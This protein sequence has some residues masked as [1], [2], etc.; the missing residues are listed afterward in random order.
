MKVAIITPY[1]N[2]TGGREKV[3]IALVNGLL[4]K[5]SDIEIHLFVGAIENEVRESFRG[6]VTFHEIPMKK[7]NPLLEAIS[8]FIASYRILKNTRFDCYHFHWPCLPIRGPLLYTVHSVHRKAI[9]EIEKRHGVVGRMRYFIRRYYPLPIFLEKITFSMPSAHFVAVSPKV[10]NEIQQIYG[11]PASSITVIPNP[12]VLE[13]I[14]FQRKQAWRDEV[15]RM[16][17]IDS[18]TVVIGTV[19]NRLP[20]K[21]I[22]VILKALSSMRKER[23]VLLLVGS[24]KPSAEKKLYRWAKNFGV[25]NCLYYVQGQKN[26]WRWYAAMDIFVFPSSYESYGLAFLEALYMGI[27]SIVSTNVGGLAFIPHEFINKYVF[28]LK[29]INEIELQSA[30]KTIVEN[31][32]YFINEKDVEN[33]KSFVKQLNES[34][35]KSYLQCYSNLAKLRR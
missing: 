9:W 6:E 12:L 14:D 28:C 22:D 19:A 3:V 26:V 32:L 27:P 11:V 31:Y 8:F 7:G 5:T 24:L 35:I 4:Y 25:E 10:R 23:F 1:L 30:I 29:E 18:A 34:A 15:R 20:G 16:F 21:N 33:I 17:S 2:T 13:D